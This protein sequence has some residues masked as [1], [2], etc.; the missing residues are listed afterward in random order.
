MSL[1]QIMAPVMK[2]VQQTQKNEKTNETAMTTHV[3]KMFANHNN[4]LTRILQNG[5]SIPQEL[6]E[7]II[8][9]APL[10]KKLYFGLDNRIIDPHLLP[11]D[12]G[13]FI[14]LFTDTLPI[15]FPRTFLEQGVEIQT[16]NSVPT[17]LNLVQEKNWWEITHSDFELSEGLRAGFVFFSSKSMKKKEK[18]K[19]VQ[20][21]TNPFIPD[22]AVIF[23]MR[24]NFYSLL[25]FFFA[26]KNYFQNLQTGLKAYLQFVKQGET[27]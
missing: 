17:T 7:K 10:L 19:F 9:K 12:Q 24:C 13:E 2:Q 1:E 22:R 11:N 23:S 5:L 20:V 14:V 25:L 15:V 6:Q 21:A 4:I 16:L 26:H 18:I 27:K 8:A 3:D